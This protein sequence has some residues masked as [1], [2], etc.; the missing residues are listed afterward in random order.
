MN[1]MGCKWGLHRADS[2]QPLKWSDEIATW[3]GVYRAFVAV[4]KIETTYDR[5]EIQYG[6]KG[7]QNFISRAFNFAPDDNY[8]LIVS[9]TIFI[10]SE[11]MVSGIC[12]FC[13]QKIWK[14]FNS[15]QVS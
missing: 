2:F 13:P 11:H 7:R 3:R 9:L 10:F 12:R 5:I 4:C 1:R 6:P 14:T 8:G 15:I